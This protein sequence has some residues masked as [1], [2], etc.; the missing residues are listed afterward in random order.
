[1]R[2]NIYFWYFF[3]NSFITAE[4]VDLVAVLP[5]PASPP[6]QPGV[7]A[8]LPGPP[9][10]PHARPGRPVRPVR[11]L[12]HVQARRHQLHQP[13]SF[14]FMF[15]FYIK[16]HLLFLRKSLDTCYILWLFL[17]KK[18]LMFSILF[19]VLFYEISFKRNSL[20]LWR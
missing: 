8:A 13:R 18:S 1:M 2:N 15:I 19:L 20:I 14:D 11:P 12:L 16:V 5:V 3:K 7:V 10:L 9:H 6:P 17:K 4:Q